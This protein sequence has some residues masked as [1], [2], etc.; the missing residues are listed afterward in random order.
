MESIYNVN[1]DA[2]RANWLQVRM[3][4]TIAWGVGKAET[5]ADDW[6]FRLLLAAR[7][8]NTA[9]ESWDPDQAVGNT[10]I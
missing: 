3:S 5:L 1:A 2:S 4:R 7:N 8:T 6:H 9:N 10:V